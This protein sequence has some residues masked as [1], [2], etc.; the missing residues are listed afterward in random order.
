MKQSS[1]KA[2][3]AV[4]YL[5]LLGVMVAIALTSFGTLIPAARNETNTFFKGAFTNIIGENAV[6]SVTG[7]WPMNEVPE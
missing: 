7:P 2:Q 5:V 1:Q 3:S 6:T 4:E